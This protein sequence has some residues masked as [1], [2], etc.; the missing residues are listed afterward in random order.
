MKKRVFAA[1]APLLALAACGQGDDKAMSMTSGSQSEWSPQDKSNLE[2]AS[3]S[4]TSQN[5]EQVDPVQVDWLWDSAK[6]R[7]QSPG[8]APGQVYK[9]PKN[10]EEATAQAKEKLTSGFDECITHFTGVAQEGFATNQQGWNEATERYK[11]DK[12]TDF[13]GTLLPSPAAPEMTITVKFKDAATPVELKASNP[14]QAA[15]MR[16]S[17]SAMVANVSYSK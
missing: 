16:K 4:I 2:S 14:N 5:G 11:T 6:V 3:C 8:E 1:V 9:I 10:G 17:V 12:L 13:N 7:M 15:Q